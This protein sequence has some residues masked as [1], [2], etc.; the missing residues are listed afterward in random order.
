MERGRGLG[1][2]GKRNTWKANTSR[3]PSWSGSGFHEL[4]SANSSW[5][6]PLPRALCLVL[7]VQRRVMVDSL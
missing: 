7:G 3:R 5:V 2:V 1:A 6:L 4:S